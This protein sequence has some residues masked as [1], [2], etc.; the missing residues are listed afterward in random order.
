MLPNEVSAAPRTPRRA[1]LGAHRLRVLVGLTAA[2]SLLAGS[3]APAAE[4]E[5][6]ALHETRRADELPTDTQI[7]PSCPDGVCP[8]LGNSFYLPA[9]NGFSPNTGGSE[10]F[11]NKRLGA[12]ARLSPTARATREFR[13][14]AS[15]EQFTR[16]T[17]S[18]FD[19]NASYTTA[20]LTV[21]GTAQAMTGERSDRTSTF[22][23]IH[24]DITTTTHTVNLVQSPDCFAASNIDPRYL[25]QFT[26]LAL[27]DP[28]QVGSPTA[29]QPYAAFLTTHGSHIMMQQQLGS[30]FQ[31]WESSTT[32]AEDVLNTLKAKA[33]AGVEGTSD[34]G[35]GWSVQG[36]AAYSSEE[37]RRALRFESSTRQVV[38]GGTE[39]TRIALTQDV[40]KR[41]LD[42]FIASASQGDQAIHFIFK[43]VWEL[44]FVIYTPACQ[45]A[46][47][48]SSACQNLQRA[49]NLQAAYEGWTAIGC[50]E[51]KDGRGSVYQTMAVVGDT[52]QGI[53][54]YKCQAAKTGCRSHDDCRVGGAGSV[55]YCYGPGCIDQGDI[56]AGT[57]LFRNR[58]RGNREG[59]YDHGVNNSC[60]FRLKC[61]CDTSWSGG[62]PS[63]TLYLQAAPVASENGA[64][65]RL[66]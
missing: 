10:F 7:S 8:G 59:D 65:G 17:M 13:S 47:R 50:P 64:G 14:V 42:A 43:P 16:A 27:I 1:H 6:A 57:E 36:C 35:A 40:N 53:Q 48:G 52:T 9:I 60:N 3:Q 54:T 29:W 24:M 4:S 18:S 51:L 33:C 2:V 66:E 55:C 5:A 61:Y 20:R 58:V 41:T 44:F 11:T 56:V 28:S 30:R 45:A 34:A 63:R 21:T 19:L 46:G 22:N 39:A 38:M 23:S 12:C 32:S 37:R 15:M 49:V 26:A 31:K 62:L 25:A